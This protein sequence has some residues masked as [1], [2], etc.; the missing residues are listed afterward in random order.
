MFLR[1]VN[2]YDLEDAPFVEK[3]VAAGAEDGGAAGSRKRLQA[4]L[5]ELKPVGG[6]S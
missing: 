4:V 3:P 5:D 2:G 1:P 6:A